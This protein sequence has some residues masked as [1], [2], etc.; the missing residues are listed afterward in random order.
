MEDY[1][2]PNDYYLTSQQLLA[3]GLVA[4]HNPASWEV[5]VE[6]SPNRYAI[7]TFKSLEA[8][9][10]N[11]YADPKNARLIVRHATAYFTIEEYARLKVEQEKYDNGDGRGVG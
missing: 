1:R 10:E 8:A 9:L 11:F 5:M 4:E 2:L 3:Q 7:V 6:V